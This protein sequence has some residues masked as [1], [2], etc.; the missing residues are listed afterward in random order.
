MKKTMTLALCAAVS[1]LIV[2]SQ[3]HAAPLVAGDFYMD[4]GRYTNVSTVG[5]ATNVTI[6]TPTGLAWTPIS[7]ADLRTDGTTNVNTYGIRWCSGSTTAR[8]FRSAAST[9]G[10]EVSQSVKDIVPAMS[11]SGP[12]LLI[13]GSVSNT[14]YLLYYRAALKQQ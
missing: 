1:A 3:L 14:T 2:T 9:G 13:D 8:V 10:S 4:N 5:T 7:I 12:K 11:E 6:T